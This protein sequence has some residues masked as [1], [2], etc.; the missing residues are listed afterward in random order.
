[1]SRQNTARADR[2]RGRRQR[3]KAAQPPKADRPTLSRELAW[4]LSLAAMVLMLVALCA[5]RLGLGYF[6]DD[7]IF[8]TS[9]QANPLAFILPNPASTIFYRPISMGLYF[10]L[11]LA[12]GPWG[13]FL[14]HVLNLA[15]LGAC[16]ILLASLVARV[17][18]RRAG[19]CAGFAFAALSSVP[20][21]V[22]WI[23][24][25]QDILAI[26]FLLIAFHLRHAGRTLGTL[27]A[28]ACAVF[29][30]ET[31]LALFPA[32]LLWPWILARKPTRLLSNGLLLGSLVALWATVHPGVHAFLAHGIRNE[33]TG[34][35]HLQNPGNWAAH[36]G[37][38][39]LILFNLPVTGYPDAWPRELTPF[40][41]GAA[42]ILLAGLWIGVSRIPPDRPAESAPLSRIGA[43]A[44]L[45]VLPPLVLDTA[46]VGH[47]A[48]YYACLPGIGGALLLGVM[49]SKLPRGISMALLA[50]FLLMG[51]RCRG[52]DSPDL[53]F[54][55]RNM[56]AGSRAVRIVEKRF[57]QLRPT[58]PRAAELLISVGATGTL[59]MFQ[60]IHQGQAPRVW[61]GDPTL[62]ARPPEQWK[63]GTP[64][65]LFRTTSFLGVAE[66]EPES[67]GYIWAGEIEPDQDEIARPIRAFARGAAAC[68]LTDQ[69]VRIL[70][71][72]SSLP[73]DSMRDYDKRLT[74][75][76]LLA[77]GRESEA[78][79]ILARVP[80]F[81]RLE[82]LRMVKKLLNEPTKRP[83]VDSSVFR[84][85]GLSEDDPHD[86]RDLLRLFRADGEMQ[87]AAYFAVRLQRLVPGDPESAGILR[88]TGPSATSMQPP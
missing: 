63:G 43:L 19:I 73:P 41:L 72:I 32:L 22:A 13:A 64:W 51:V 86:V 65:L 55:E 79:Q 67:L 40:A 26:L 17:A 60:T 88:K 61:Y 75:L 81:P 9:S 66:I 8:L 84:A 68:G 52:I 38:Y 59:G 44:A 76:A 80:P 30:K 42:A 78:A 83:Q 3:G 5:P 62:D 18:G 25:S 11:L 23:T 48:P 47:W 34:Y 35:V 21:L 36:I 24:T 69:A 1:M 20:A 10:L 82:T 28:A 29:S 15:L 87:Q 2:R 54:T 27:I 74:A 4:K 53:A 37:R 58:M 12:L 39:L 56:V 6:W 71:K 57:R 33:T 16:V 45:L 49:L 31:A 70:R 7:Y 85:F 14:G 77:G 50:L 46:M